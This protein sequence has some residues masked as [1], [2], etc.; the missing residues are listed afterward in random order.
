[1]KRASTD[2]SEDPFRREGCQEVEVKSDF[3]EGVWQVCM[4]SKYMYM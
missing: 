4:K 1:M 3:I 2:V